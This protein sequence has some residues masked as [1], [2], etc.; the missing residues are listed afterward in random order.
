MNFWLPNIR[1]VFKKR[2]KLGCNLKFNQF[3]KLSGLGKIYIGDTCSFGYKPGGFHRYGS[4]EIQA[5]TPNA[6]VKIGSRVSTNNNIFICSSGE[7]TIGENT[8]IGQSVTIMDFEAHGIDSSSRRRVG[9]IGRI[10]IENNVW[11]GNNVIILKNTEIGENSIV[12][13]GAVVSGN[14]PANVILGGVPAKI[15]R[16]IE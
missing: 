3:T 5:R 15:I 4:I 16:R 10:R 9:L 2:I 8:L 12:A 1:I 11:I 13:A 7:I 14:F 6:L